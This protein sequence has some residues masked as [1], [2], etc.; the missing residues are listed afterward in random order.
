MESCG[1]RAWRSGAG[2]WSVARVFGWIFSAALAFSACTCQKDI[3]DPPAR[4]SHLRDAKR[5]WGGLKD[6]RPRDF[7]ERGEIEHKIPTKRPRP[8]PLPTRDM[9]ADDQ[10]E[11]PDD[12]PSDVPV[13]EGA[14]VFGVQKLAAG[15]KNV[16]FHT[17]GE[18]PEVF[19]YYRDSMSGDG[20]NVE[21]EYQQ[22]NQSF[23]SFTKDG[24][25][26]N[27]TVAHDP[28]TGKQIIAVM[29]YKEQP[30]PFEEF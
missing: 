5:G 11:I 18:V 10:T 19:N 17:D 8:S 26:T 4:T 16:L 24:M 13:F 3:P 9:A 20:W 7:A 25:I 21:Q 22:G 2:A 6:R 12:F 23:L 30:L 29:Y 1:A 27:M 15:A 14:E 28:D